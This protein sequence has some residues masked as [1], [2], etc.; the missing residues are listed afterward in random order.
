MSTPGLLSAGVLPP[1]GAQESPI[2]STTAPLSPSPLAASTVNK[3]TITSLIY[4][5]DIFLFFQ[6]LVMLRTVIVDLIA[7]NFSVGKKYSYTFFPV[8]F[9]FIAMLHIFF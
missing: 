4:Q 7:P 9:V 2:T 3:Q 5:S 8:H 1:V 6:K